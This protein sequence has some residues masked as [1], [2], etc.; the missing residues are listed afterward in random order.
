[1]ASKKAREAAIKK[2]SRIV[3]GGKS[4]FVRRASEVEVVPE[5]A[6]SRLADQLEARAFELENEPNTYGDGLGDGLAQ[7]AALLRESIQAEEEGT[8]R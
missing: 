4:G 5:S 8:E 3:A 1:M 7:A 6:L 2:A